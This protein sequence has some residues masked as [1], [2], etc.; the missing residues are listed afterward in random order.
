[1]IELRKWLGKSCGG[2]TLIEMA[3]VLIITGL[4]LG[5]AIKAIHGQTTKRRAEKSFDQL[6]EIREA[7]LGFA[8]INGRLP[9]PDTDFDGLENRAAGACVA[10]ASGQFVGVVPWTTLG[11]NPVDSWS[12]LF[13]Y[14]VTGLFADDVALAT[15]GTGTTTGEACPPAVPVACPAAASA[16]FSLK[17]QCEGDITLQNAAGTT[18]VTAI[19]AV[20]LSHGPNGYG[21]YLPSGARMPTSGA[22]AAELENSDLTNGTYRLGGDD[23]VAWIS[24]LVLKYRMVKAGRLP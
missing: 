24:P 16:S 5:G 9:C 6:Q 21:A 15:T 19:P 10:N 11:V 7:I 2:F 14:Q 20:F 13:S 17:C 22:H 8:A 1:M 4:L 18:M 12:H 3:M 23:I